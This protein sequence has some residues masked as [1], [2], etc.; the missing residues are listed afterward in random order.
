MEPRCV[1]FRTV[2]LGDYDPGVGVN[3]LG[4]VFQMTGPTHKHVKGGLYRKIGEGRIEATLEPVVVYES[5]EGEIWV[6]PTANFNE[7]FAPLPRELIP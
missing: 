3:F 6:R 7:R 1:A 5:M 2:V 4:D